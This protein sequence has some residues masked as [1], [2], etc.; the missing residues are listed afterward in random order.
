MV[1]L[2]IIKSYTIS[3]SHSSFVE[4]PAMVVDFYLYFFYFLLDF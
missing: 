4:F 2:Y 3:M 1:H